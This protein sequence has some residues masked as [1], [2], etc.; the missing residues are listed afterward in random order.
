MNNKYTTVRRIA[1]TTG[2][3]LGAFA[4]AA[5]ANWTP[6]PGTPPSCPSGQP[7]CDAPINVGSV[8]Q[9]RMGAIGLGETSIPTG[10]K[11]LLDIN[12]QLSANAV[13]TNQLQVTGGTLAAGN[14][15]TSDVNGNATWQAP[16]ASSGSYLV[17]YNSGAQDL[18]NL[19]E[20]TAK[21]YDLSG[22]GVPST[23]HAALLN[24]RWNTGSANDCGGTVLTIAPNGTTPLSVYQWLPLSGGIDTSQ[25]IVQAWV[26][27][28]NGQ[29][30]LYDS[31]TP[32]GGVCKFA[33]KYV[34]Y[35]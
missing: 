25:P 12:G 29:I 35:M 11:S 27:I 20:T 14:V 34:G 24:I 7:G 15:L 31:M 19:Q 22:Y 6:P 28:R 23:A 26:P 17:F 21:A 5:L 2:F 1:V 32:S 33:A 13:V 18:G 10:L 8:A 9:T 4:L 16:G 3:L 30:Y